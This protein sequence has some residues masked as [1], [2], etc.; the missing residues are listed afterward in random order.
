MRQREKEKKRLEDKIK[1]LLLTT[2]IPVI[3][4]MAVLL[5]VFWQYTRQYSELSRNLA[6]SSEFNLS[7]KDDVDE[8]IYY[9]AI[10]SKKSE[11]LPYDL[12]RQAVG[13]VGRLEKT[14]HRKESIKSIRNL[15]FYL[16]N[17]EEYMTELT[18]TKKYDDRISLLE[19]YIYMC[20]SLIM[21]EM[22]NYIYQESMNLVQVESQ[23]TDTGRMLIMGMAVLIILT[24][25]ILMRRFFRF[26]YKITEPIT[27]ILHNVKAVGKGNF[28]MKSVE[29]D[30]LEIQELDA[31]T[32]KMA[33]RIQVL[34]ENVKKDQEMQHLTELQLLQAQVNPHFL[35]NTLDTIVWLIE[36]GQDQ[37]ALN[38]IT[39]L[40]VFFR[41][42][43]S[44][45]NDII[46]LEEE[47]SHTL[48]YLEIQ[49]FRYR[50]ILEFE[51][52]IPRSLKKI[53]V[54]K[55]TL[56]PLAENALYHG[57]KNK[58]GKGKILI[59]GIDLGE[60]L[61]L[62]VTDT[63]QGMT[64]E[65]LGEVQNAIRTGKRAG[66]GLAAVSE[67]IRL[68]YGPG[69]GLKISSKEGSGTVME[70]YLG[71]KIKN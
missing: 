32:R 52:N 33:E 39:S 64:G 7:F 40:S 34:L 17:L 31:G 46:T 50:D 25:V 2:M 51:I 67:R 71:K 27:E 8:R 21:E 9:V 20:T 59:E 10:G 4:I 66:F 47:E 61:I 36:G 24:V 53:L 57:I 13:T 70:I 23:L 37:D 6:V 42:S 63:G 43:L 19:N 45:G 49:Q 56:Q 30:S 69:Y 3:L 12:V 16:S 65:R 55:L 15:K 5:F 14:T 54:P 41:T 35:Y 44:K 29:A 60:D 48:S 1:M 18:E 28:H 22:Q 26:S 11:T 68:Y 38:M 62:R 58:R